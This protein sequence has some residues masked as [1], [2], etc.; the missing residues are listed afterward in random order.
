[1]PRLSVILPTYNER[2]NIKSLILAISQSVEPRP[3]IVVV[4]DN[5]PDGTGEIVSE[6]QKQIPDLKLY[7]REERGLAT[8]LIRGICHSSGDV[9][10][11]MDC[12]FSHP[13]DLLPRMLEAMNDHDAAIASRYV[14]GGGQRYPLVR[15][16]TSRAFNIWA[17]LWFG[18]SVHDWTSGYAMVKREV[19]DKVNIRPLGQ[20]YGEYFVGMLY[21][22]VKNGFKVKEIPYICVYNDNHKSKTSTNIVKLLG[23]GISYG[24]SVPKLRFKALRNTL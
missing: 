15:N 17:S 10:A 9:L 4:D 12:D 1:M 20:G 13:P 5:S 16:V 3:E 7:V 24:M 18:F 14:K 2:E 11:W 22:M 21:G 23:F 8:A 19:L 6:L